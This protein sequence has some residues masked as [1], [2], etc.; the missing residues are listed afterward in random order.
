MSKLSLLQGNEAIFQA[1]VKAG[2]NFYGGY[3]ITPSSEITHSAAKAAVEEENLH[4]IQFE[5]E[6]ASINGII[7]AALGG[8]KVMTATSGPGFSLMQEGLGL[9]H[10][11]NI[12]LV[13]VDVQRVGPSTGMPTM[14]AQGDILQAY[15]GS[16]GDYISL[17]LAPASV[18]ECYLYTLQAFNLAQETQL[19]VILLIDGYLGHLYET[20]NPDKF[21][22]VK[23][24]NSRF[25]PFGKGKR[26]L[27]GLLSDNGIPKT[28][29]SQFYSQW[30]NKRKQK[31]KQLIKN[32]EFFEYIPHKKSHELIISYGITS[33]L[34]TPYE[35]HFAFFRPIRLFP[36]LE[37]KLKEITKNYSQIIVIEMN[38]GQYAQIIEQV[39]KRK[40]KKIRL[41][42]GEINPQALAK[43][44]IYD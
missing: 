19:P 12:P 7:G 39:L 5:D 18:E 23:I 3:P 9:A 6:L 38:D 14:P 30:F 34:L 40:V 43:Q 11:A 10:M 17:C 15:H 36:V 25:K 28:K 35:N 27:T 20:I 33:R 22:K 1:A 32:Y 13:L 44:L 37:K 8:A 24:I 26:H 41:F 2:L 31:I 29:D 16:H 21:K 4:F 42:G